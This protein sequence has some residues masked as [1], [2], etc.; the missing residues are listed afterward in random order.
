MVGEQNLDL[1][2]IVTRMDTHRALADIA[3]KRGI[4][5]IV[6]KPIAGRLTDAQAMVV[7]AETAGVFLQFTRTSASRRRCARRAN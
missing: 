6:Q 1:V 4:P 2:D 5:A 3:V 7:A